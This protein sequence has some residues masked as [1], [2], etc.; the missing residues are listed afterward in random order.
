MCVDV[1]EGRDLCVDGLRLVAAEEAEG[2]VE[3]A[4][5]GE[6]DGPRGAA[7]V[8]LADLVALI[9]RLFQNIRNGAHANMNA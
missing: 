3:T 1:M 4:S 5:E 8:P 2:A 9:A 7:G 6:V